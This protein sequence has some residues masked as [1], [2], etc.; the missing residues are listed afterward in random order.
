MF[1]GGKLLSRL[2]IDDEAVDDFI[3]L[4]PLCRR[5]AILI[6]SDKSN[7]NSPL[8]ATKLR[9]QKEFV[10]I[11]APCW[12]TE[13]REIENFYSRGDRLEAVQSVHSDVSGLAG[14]NTRYDKPISFKRTGKPDEVVADK[15]A[16]A[17]YLVENKSPT[18]ES[19]AFAQ[20]LTEIIEYIRAAND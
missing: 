1:Y 17:N 3:K 6:D 19:A 8:R 16:V 7:G 13:G 4:L 2:T 10:K 5:P 11:E 18:I 20:H 15:I 9:I 14:G 12:I